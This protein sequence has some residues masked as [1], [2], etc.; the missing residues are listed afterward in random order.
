MSFFAVY[1]G[2]CKRSSDP[3]DISGLDLLAI[4]ASAQE[5]LPV[6]RMEVATSI[7]SVIAAKVASTPKYILKNLAGLKF[8]IQIK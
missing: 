1:K 7:T 8:K 2:E 4:I 3:F 5:Y 6:G